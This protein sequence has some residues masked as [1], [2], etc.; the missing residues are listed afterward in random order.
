MT[1]VERNEYKI[2]LSLNNRPIT[3]VVIDQHYKISHPEMS[4][5]LVLDLV[6]T[7]DGLSLNKEA[8]KDGFEYFKIDPLYFL[9][10]PYRLIFL[11][12]IGEDY[13]GVINAF[14]VKGIK[15]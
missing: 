13:L 15:Q 1:S 2:L 10:K 11:I 4:D 12:C 7:I 14:R 8:E 5:E 3:R 9:E 6:K